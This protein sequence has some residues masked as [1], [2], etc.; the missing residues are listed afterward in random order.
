MEP[1]LLQPLRMCW[2]CLGMR[3]TSLAPGER[4][5]WGRVKRESSPS[6]VARGHWKFWEDSVHWV[7]EKCRMT[8]I[9]YSFPVEISLFLNPPSRPLWCRWDSVHWAHGTP[10]NIS[11]KPK[12]QQ[13]REK[14]KLEVLWL[15]EWYICCMQ[16]L[17][18]MMLTKLSLVPCVLWVKFCQ[19]GLFILWAWSLLWGCW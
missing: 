18:E 11:K 9:L 3:R 13:C 19:G 5:G 17:K 8:E 15:Q 2:P 1:L 14:H 6:S 16:V 10:W 12:K 7:A 4:W